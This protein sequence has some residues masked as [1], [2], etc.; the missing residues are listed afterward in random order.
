MEIVLGAIAALVLGVVGYAIGSARG[1]PA[2][3]VE[4]GGRADEQVRRI[5]EALA[6]GQ[7]PPAAEPGS[8][9]AELHA[10]LM[11][12]W[13]P[14]EQERQEALREAVG[15][16]AAYLDKEVR[17][18]LAGAGPNA[19]AE[20]LR[21]RAARALGALQ[22]V[23]FFLREPA[24]ST[25]G[26]NV[27]ALVQQVA[28]EFAADQQATLRLQLGEIP[29]RADV[30]ATALMDAL[31]LILHNASRFGGR[32]AIDVTV[33]REPSRARIV[34]RD[35]GPGFSEEAFGRAFDP[36]YST[37]DS[38]LGLGLPHARRLIEA[39]GGRIELRNVP[40]GGAEVEVS[41]PAR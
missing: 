30:N 19:D 24:T 16:V 2:A 25:E 17:E 27:T 5:A 26:R 21:E 1:G 11:R 28:R 33:A 10:A 40:D 18:P 39:M 9:A 35:R 36:F 31:Y 29:A 15:R 7:R 3:R 22:D 37:S 38:G 20:E 34:V 14:R 6:R 41:L 32:G 12:G 8:A 13:A 4:G 23:E